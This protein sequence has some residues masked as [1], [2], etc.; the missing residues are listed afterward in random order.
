MFQKVKDFQRQN[1]RRICFTSLGWET[2]N[3]RKRFHPAE[4]ITVLLSHRNGT[5]LLGTTLLDSGTG[6]N[7]AEAVK[8]ILDNWGLDKQ[9]VSMCFDTTAS[10]T[11]KF[12]GV[13]IIL[14]ERL[15]IHWFG[16]LAAIIYTKLYFPMFLKTSSETSAFHKWNFLRYWK[17][18]EP[19]L[20]SQNTQHTSQIP[21]MKYLPTK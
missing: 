19:L 13:C 15:I 1:Q 7:Q 17:R 18:N 10:N 11:G 20:I 6:K 8:S 14:Q 2:S 3:G 12:N 4:H 16:R 21:P 5:K 9:C